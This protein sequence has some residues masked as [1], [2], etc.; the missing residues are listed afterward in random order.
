M[1]PYYFAHPAA[2]QFLPSKLVG[3]MHCLDRKQAKAVPCCL[4][5]P[6]T[7]SHIYESWIKTVGETRAGS[8]KAEPATERLTS[9]SSLT[10]SCWSLSSPKASI[11]KPSVQ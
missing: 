4:C 1:V 5:P 9:M 7:F 2:P 3:G 6:P 10:C 11:I 8:N